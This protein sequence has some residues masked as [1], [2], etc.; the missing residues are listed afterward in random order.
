MNVQDYISSGILETY[1]LGLAGEE[2]SR[3]LE[4]LCLQYP[5]LKSALD[6]AEA[7]M[8]QYAQLHAVMP[9][10]HLKEQIWSQLQQQAVQP[11]TKVVAMPAPQKAV[12]KLY[13]YISV[14]GLL[15]L[16]VGIPYHY[17][18]MSSYQKEISTLKKEKTDI[19]V[20]SK[21]FQAQLKQA[22]AEMEIFTAQ[23]TRRIELSGVAGHEG[24]T[25]TV[26]LDKKGAAYMNAGALPKLPATQQYQ[27]WAIVKGKPVSAGLVS[28][29]EDGLLQ[30]MTMV[31]N[32]EMYAVTIEV[33]GGSE[34]PTLS[35]MVVA[36]KVL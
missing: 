12:V 16:V 24:M 3:E 27:L 26:L 30:E 29:I 25:A 22:G 17:Y 9:P 28:Q 14:A 23:D 15:L 13:P 34:V 20:Q 1:L 11:E 2:E 31:E 33:Q 5:E 32:A 21:N 10:V 36:G 18:R 4:Q 6:E 19:L 8:E 35:Q 7:A